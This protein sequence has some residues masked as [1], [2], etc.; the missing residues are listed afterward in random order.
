M[1]CVSKPG[2]QEHCPADTSKGVVLVSSTGEAPCLLGK[3]WGYDDTGI[4][5]ADGC[6]A[7]FLAGQLPEAPAKAKPLSH[8]PSVKVPAL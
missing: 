3:T 1:P 7:R 2:G 6:S 5:V 8:I 4:W